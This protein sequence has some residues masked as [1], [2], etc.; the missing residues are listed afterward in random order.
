M[1]ELQKLERISPLSF[2]EIIAL[3]FPCRRYSSMDWN[4]AWISSSDGPVWALPGRP[5]S[6]HWTPQSEEIE[7]MHHMQLQEDA[8]PNVI[9]FAYMVAQDYFA[10]D[11]PK[12]RTSTS[13]SETGEPALKL[14]AIYI[15]SLCTQ[16]HSTAQKV[17]EESRLTFEYTACF[18]ILFCTLFS[19]AFQQTLYWAHASLTQQLIDTLLQHC[20]GHICH[21]DSS[22]V[23]WHSSLLATAGSGRWS[24]SKIGNL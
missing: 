20:Q 22:R 14:Q 8:E 23:A 6:S 24:F 13:H 16:R 10:T 2:L 4:V 1:T 12:N 7:C 21:L 18:S 17:V 3:K 15:P 11:W 9:W 19:R 5:L